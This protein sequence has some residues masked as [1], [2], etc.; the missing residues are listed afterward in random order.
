MQLLDR[1]GERRAF[2][3]DEHERQKGWRVDQSEPDQNRANAAN[4]RRLGMPV[5]V[6]LATKALIR[7]N[8]L[9]HQ[10]VL[11]SNFSIFFPD[12]TPRPAHQAIVDRRRWTIYSRAI[13]PASPS[14]R[15]ARPGPHRL[16]DA[17]A[18]R[19]SS[20]A[21][22]VARCPRLAGVVGTPRHSPDLPYR[23]SVLNPPVYVLARRGPACSQAVWAALFL[24]HPR[25]H[26]AGI[27]AD[28]AAASHL[29]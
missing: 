13:A 3:K 9:A 4:I 20:H 28:Y 22:R 11:H 2:P 14:G 18:V 19:P 7:K 8:V 15:L 25:H 5:C 10:N 29:N 21:R 12:A 27:V 17:L 6:R 1:C 24:S 26:A 23:A 16:T